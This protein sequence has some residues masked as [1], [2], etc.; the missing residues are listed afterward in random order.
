MCVRFVGRARSRRCFGTVGIWLRVWGVRGSWRIA[1][2]VGG[3]LGGWLSC[4]LREEVG[5]K[6]GGV[7]W[8]GVWE[9]RRLCDCFGGVDVVHM[10]G[11]KGVRA[12]VPGAWSLAWESE[13]KLLTQASGSC[14]TSFHDITVGI[15][16]ERVH[17]KC[18]R[19]NDAICGS[20]AI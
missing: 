4:L 6:G 14:G 10:G 2:F 19:A 3:R 9:K 18:G 7:G 13:T 12:C 17:T 11:G 16:A 20:T 5:G 8:G 1:L 15:R